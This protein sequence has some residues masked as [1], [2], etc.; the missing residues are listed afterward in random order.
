MIRFTRDAARVLGMPCREHTVL[1]SRQMDAPLSRGETFGL[2]VHLVIC[3]G[4][5]RFKAQM[6]QLRSMSRSLGQAMDQAGDMPP[7]VRERITAGIRAD[8]RG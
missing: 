7:A 2:R 5:R 4:C 3:A 8:K 1:L 6:I